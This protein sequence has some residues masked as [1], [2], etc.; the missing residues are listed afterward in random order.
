MQL[1]KSRFMLGLQCHRRLWWTVHEPDAPELEVDD[2]QQI[3]FD[4]GTEVGEVARTHIPGGIL[5]D[6]PHYAVRERI[7]ETKRSIESGAH[8]IYEASFRVD[9]LYVAVD[10]LHRRGR[11]WT[12]TEVKSTTS[13]KPEHVPDVGIQTHVL[14]RAGLDVARAEVMHLNRDCRHPDLRNLFIRTDVTDR[15]EQALPTIGREARKQLRMLEDELPDVE[16]GQQCNRPYDCP[17]QTRCLDEPPEHHVSTLYRIGP[18]QLDSLVAEGFESIHDLPDDLELGGIADRQRR[19]VQ[20]GSVVVEP[21]LGEALAELEHP[22]AY[23]DFE[24]IGLPIPIWPGCRPYDAVPVQFSSHTERADG[25]LEHHE[26]LAEGRDDPR[27][28]LAAALIRAV[29]GAKTVLAYNAGF[30]LER[31]KAMRVAM[32]HLARQLGSIERRVRDL[33]P[34][35]REHVYH[36]DFGGSF[37]LKCVLP[38]LVP[39][40]GYDDLEIQDGGTATVELERLLLHGSELTRPERAKRRAAL[41]EY[42]RLDTLAMVRIVAS[43]RGLTSPSPRRRKRQ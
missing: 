29:S 2:D 42:C 23:L 26:W 41:L 16:A 33:L 15:V 14:R 27:P 39:D 35:V 5:I 8:V 11:R 9:N 21:S 6:L 37:S 1:S 38:A 32:P 20:Q 22:I 12:L 3:L 28:G 19:A 40:L 7:A 43:L 18:R 25:S 10:V 36:P 24:T 4:H 30:E 17:F 13:A 31:I 34:I